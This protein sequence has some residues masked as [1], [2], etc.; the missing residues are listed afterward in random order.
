MVLSLQT[1]RALSPMVFDAPDAHDLRF[2]LRWGLPAL[3]TYFQGFGIPRRAKHM[4]RTALELEGAQG[5]LNIC[6]RISI[7]ALRSPR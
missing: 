4:I 3:R 1:L 7:Q 6:K 2:P 5:V